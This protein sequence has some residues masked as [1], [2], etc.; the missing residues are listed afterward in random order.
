MQGGGID[1]HVLF[2]TIFGGGGGG[3]GGGMGG[4]PGVHGRLD[5]NLCQQGTPLTPKKL[6]KE[7]A[8]AGG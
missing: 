6:H 5:I 8:K 1:P 4:M 2:E 7:Q 3:M